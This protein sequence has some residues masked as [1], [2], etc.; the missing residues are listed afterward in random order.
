M[1]RNSILVS[2]LGVS[3]AFASPASADNPAS[4]SLA[5]AR[6][7]AGYGFPAS[8]G[9]VQ[10]EARLRVNNQNPDVIV[11]GGCEQAV[12]YY[13]Y[14]RSQ[15]TKFS[16]NGAL[17]P[18]SCPGACP[19]NRVLRRTYAWQYRRALRVMRN[20]LARTMRPAFRVPRRGLRWVTSLAYVPGSSTVVSLGVPVQQIAFFFD[21][22]VTGSVRMIR[23]R[24]DGCAL[25]VLRRNFSRTY[26]GLPMRVLGA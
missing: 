12:S 23:L 13:N 3:L 8:P 11:A 19:F 15:L 2:A 7:V 10:I 6:A 21:A 5:G 22:R 20:D 9:A 26:C 18:G 16:C 17:A 25:V 4:I 24:D 1:R 14:G